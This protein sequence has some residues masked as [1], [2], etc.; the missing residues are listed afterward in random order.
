[1]VRRYGVPGNNLVSN[2]HAN[3]RVFLSQLNRAIQEPW[4][5]IIDILIMNR[6][7]FHQNGGSRPYVIPPNRA[8]EV[9]NWIHPNNVK[10]GVINNGFGAWCMTDCELSLC[11]WDKYRNHNI[12]KILR[13]YSTC[14]PKLM[15]FIPVIWEIADKTPH[16]NTGGSCNM[17]A[18]AVE[19]VPHPNVKYIVDHY[20][21]AI[22][23]ERKAALRAK[24]RKAENDK[25]KDVLQRRLFEEDSNGSILV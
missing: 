18:R 15:R 19:I 23:E 16:S 10:N 12:M 1:M 3:S 2:L 17:R 5:H 22:E 6:D 13:T 20:D 25:C 4:Q 11:I 8:T 21:A 14:V 24:A 9:E 7:A